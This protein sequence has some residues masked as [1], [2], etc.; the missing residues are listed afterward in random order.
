MGNKEHTSGDPT[1]LAS[2]KRRSPRR[3]GGG[4]G[5]SGRA[6]VSTSTAIRAAVVAL[7]TVFT[8]LL[9]ASSAVGVGVGPRMEAGTGAVAASTNRATEAFQVFAG[10][11]GVFVGS[12][13]AGDVG[14]GGVGDGVSWGGCG[15]GKG[16]GRVG[17]SARGGGVDR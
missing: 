7:A 2:A 3:G 16:E 17:F 5:G 9:G 4:G 8:D 6:R 14:V 13:K 11:R 12:R 10:G 15:A 1:V